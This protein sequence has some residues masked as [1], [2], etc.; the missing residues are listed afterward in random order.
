MDFGFLNVFQVAHVK[1]D[2]WMAVMT[3][4]T[5]CASVRLESNC[6]NIK[7]ILYDH[8]IQYGTGQL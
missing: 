6:R 1:L 4:T 2:A 5:P 8:N 7:V 3:V